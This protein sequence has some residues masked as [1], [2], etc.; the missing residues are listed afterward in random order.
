MH[1]FG[2]PVDIEGLLR[3]QP[4]YGGLDGL[5]RGLAETVDWFCNS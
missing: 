1:A 4:Q 2:H 5:R 3:W